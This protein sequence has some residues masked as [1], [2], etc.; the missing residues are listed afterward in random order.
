MNTERGGTRGALQRAECAP[1]L[2]LTQSHAAFS[3]R[4]NRRDTAGVPGHQNAR[5]TRKRKDEAE[6]LRT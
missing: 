2:L 4:K 6:P 1:R 3:G 5:P